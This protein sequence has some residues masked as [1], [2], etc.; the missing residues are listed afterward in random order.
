MVPKI[1]MKLVN[2]CKDGMSTWLN[3][4]SWFVKLQISEIRIINGGIKS[5]LYCQLMV[6][7]VQIKIYWFS[8]M[9][10]YKK[11]KVLIT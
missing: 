9:D 5:E 1:H 3:A 11:K 4:G 6:Q 10:C 2:L 8:L 7:S